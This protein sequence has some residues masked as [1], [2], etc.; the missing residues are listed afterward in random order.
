[1][2]HCLNEKRVLLVISGGIAAYKCLDLIRKLREGGAT[3]RCVLTNGGAQF[4]TPLSLSTLSGEPVYSDLWALKDGQKISHIALAQEADIVV[5][6]PA[7][8]NL[9]AKMAN[10]IADD[11]ASTV[12]LATDRP[13]LIA[14]AMNFLMWKNAATQANV[15]VLKKRGMKFVGPESGMMACGSSGEG[16]MSE[17]AD[18]LGAVTLFFSAALPLNGMRALVTS[19]PT[20]EPIDPVRF[21]GNRSSGKQGYAIAAELARLG[22]E[23]VLVTGPTALAPPV[24]VK[25]V[26]VETAD[27][28]FAACEAVA[29]PDVAVFAAAVAD[30]RPAKMSKEKLKK[31]MVAAPRIELVENRDILATF[32]A[33]GKKRPR[34]V[35]GFAAETCDMAVNAKEKFKRKKCDWIVANQVGKDKVF[36]KDD[37]EVMLMRLSSSGKIN[38]AMWPRQSKEKV[39][40]KLV[41]EVAAFF[42]KKL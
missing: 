21:I 4:V 36:G 31:N 37:N 35:I 34:L 22:A 29:R 30:W 25:V 9:M 42:N 27:E 10:G 39:A 11:L 40:E 24:G 8:A 23:T 6:A 2:K 41:G 28:M 7:T 12:L 20:Y 26:Q 1:M 18:I 17:V 33:H 3:V 19:G 32:S 5:V 14:P 15:A 38:K 13:I 16:R